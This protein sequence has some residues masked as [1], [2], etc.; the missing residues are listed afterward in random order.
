MYW[1]ADA[2]LASEIHCCNC[3]PASFR[4]HITDE[5]PPSPLTPFCA[6]TSTFLLIPQYIFF[7]PYGASATFNNQIHS[8]PSSYV[9]R[10]QTHQIVLL[11]IPVFACTMCK[12][13]FV[14]PSFQF[15]I[16]W[17]SRLTTHTQGPR[18]QAFWP[19]HMKGFLAPHA[20]LCGKIGILI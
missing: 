16:P 9:C 10:T 15:H 5:S 17:P 4:S 3:W 1:L 14:S 8:F 20:H 13:V 18:A 12:T 11:S 19:T 6:F 7:L 2:S